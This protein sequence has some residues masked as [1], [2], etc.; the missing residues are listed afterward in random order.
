MIRNVTDRKGSVRKAKKGRNTWFSSVTDKNPMDLVAGML[1][2]D[3]HLLAAEVT[4]HSCV[5]SV[6]SQ[7]SL[8]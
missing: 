3:D 7:S 8:R 4:S 5:Q 2:L 1:S 6:H